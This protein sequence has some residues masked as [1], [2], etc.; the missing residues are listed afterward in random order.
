MAVT[1]KTAVT[2]WLRV[3]TQGT[4]TM[5]TPASGYGIFYDKAKSPA[6][7]DSDGTEYILTAGSGDVVGPSSATDGNLAVFDSTTGK[8]IKDGGAV[9]VAGLL[10]YSIYAGTTDI[11]TAGTTFS[12]MTDMKGTI[13]TG[14]S[15]L[16]ILSVITAS[17][18]ANGGVNTYQLSI[19]G[20]AV[21]TIGGKVPSATLGEPI[22]LA[23]IADVSAGTHVA[24]IQWKVNANTGYNRPATIENESRTLIL[25]EFGK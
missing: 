5:S 1:L 9:P 14:A 16:D 19:D 24:N 21:K 13:I 25:K 3:K 17:N 2:D 22:A 8:L 12:D 4:A 18:S 11:S 23:Y 15:V 20:T 7:M 10:Q 6:F